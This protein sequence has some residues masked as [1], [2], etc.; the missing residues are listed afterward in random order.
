MSHGHR[1]QIHENLGNDAAAERDRQLAV[2][3]P[4]QEGEQTHPTRY[5]QSIREIDDTNPS[6]RTDR[7]CDN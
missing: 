3:S 7:Y 6:R 2:Q 4:A 5:K 1:A